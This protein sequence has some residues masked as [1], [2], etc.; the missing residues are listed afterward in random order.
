[1][2]RRSFTKAEQGSKF[3]PSAFTLTFV[4]EVVGL[5]VWH[6]CNEGWL[7]LGP[8]VHGVK[9]SYQLYPGQSFEVNVVIWPHVAKVRCCSYNIF[10]AFAPDQLLNKSNKIAG[11]LGNAGETTSKRL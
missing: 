8:P 3:C 7:D 9:L 10:Y 2:T 6:D 11:G 1:M 5:D 4:V